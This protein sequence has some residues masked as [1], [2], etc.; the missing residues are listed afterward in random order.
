MLGPLT[1]LVMDSYDNINVT[2]VP[3]M[4]NIIILDAELIINKVYLETRF[5]LGIS[6]STW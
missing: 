2:T 4:L 5:C 6:V 3:T 1:E